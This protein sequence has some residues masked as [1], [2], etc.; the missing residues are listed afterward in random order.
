MYRIVKNYIRLFVC[1]IQIER[2]IELKDFVNTLA[3]TNSAFHLTE[4]E[5]QQITEIRDVFKDCYYFTKTSQSEQ[6]TLSDFYAEWTEMKLKLKN[7]PVCF[8]VDNLIHY[9]NE[10]EAQFLKS[11]VVLAALFLDARFRVLLKEKPSATQ[12]AMS[13]LAC[14][15]RRL[16]EMKRTN[17]TNVAHESDDAHEFN[18]NQNTVDVNTASLEHYLDSLESTE[19]VSTNSGDYEEIMIKLTQFENKMKSKKR[20][21]TKKHAMDFWLAHKAVYPEL[22]QLA[23]VVFAVAAT[24]VSVERNFSALAFI[25]NKYRCSLGDDILDIILFIRLN[26]SMF[27]EC[28]NQ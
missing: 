22:F 20:E 8:F 23:E 25:L 14:L 17:Q 12:T 21:S 18:G 19:A 5:W 11:P 7:K 24:E 28:I 10:R 16:S 2:F 6:T 9:M 13:H 27:Y 15:W 4:S 1:I 3:S 26:R